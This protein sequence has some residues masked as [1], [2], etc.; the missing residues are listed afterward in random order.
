MVNTEYFYEEKSALVKPNFKNHLWDTM[1]ESVSEIAQSC[2]TLCDP[3][4][5]AREF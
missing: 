5:K 4:E 1:S 2:P 3:I